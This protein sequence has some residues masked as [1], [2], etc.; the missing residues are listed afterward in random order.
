MI[1]LIVLGLSMLVGL[2]VVLANP[3]IGWSN[4]FDFARSSACTGLWTASHGRPLFTAHPSGPLPFFVAGP[5]LSES[6]LPSSDHLF[7]WLVVSWVSKG[8]LIATQWIGLV[9]FIA[10]IVPVSWLA[11]RTKSLAIVWTIAL[12]YFLVFAN[13][14]TLGFFNT[15]YADS[16]VII[17]LYLSAI[18]LITVIYDRTRR[19]WP[20]FLV[21]CFAMGWLALSKLQAY[22]FALLMLLG[23][24]VFLV[25]IRAWRVLP[26]VVITFAIVIPVTHTFQNP[27]AYP[28]SHIIKTANA[29]DALYGVMLP[30]IAQHGGLGATGIPTE[31]RRFVGATWYT[32]TRSADFTHCSEWAAGNRTKVTLRY[33]MTVGPPIGDLHS[34]LTRTSGLTPRDLALSD[35]PTQPGNV[36]HIAENLSVLTQLSRSVSASLWA[37]SLMF[38]WWPLGM[39][40]SVGAFLAHRRRT[41]AFWRGWLAVGVVAGAGVLIEVAFSL[42]ALLGDGIHEYTRHS[43]PFVVGLA[44]SIT[45]VAL[46][47]GAAMCSPTGPPTS[48]AASSGQG[49]DLGAVLSDADGVLEVRRER[50]ILGDDPPTVLEGEGLG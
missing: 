37:N 35:H 39:V 19:T 30:A 34:V 45:A 46:F 41:N 3:V 12:S 44:L 42:S 13:M 40:L 36:K 8:G 29:D 32:A 26:L 47:A 38:V 31:C 23:F 2:S 50:A 6:C 49:E 27:T 1:A 21:L 11:L 22:P 7:S 4:N 16:S 9:H 20:S 24:G 28:F 15:L 43:Y 14:T 17:S 10:L 48:T 25:R 33:A 5:R 18:L